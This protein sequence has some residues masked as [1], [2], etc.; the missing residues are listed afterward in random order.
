MRFTTPCYIPKDIFARLPISKLCDDVKVG[1]PK[2]GVGRL[3]ADLAPR[4][5]GGRIR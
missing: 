5:K 4:I 2:S 3:T 1:K